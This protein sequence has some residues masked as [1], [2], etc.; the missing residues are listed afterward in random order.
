MDREPELI[1]TPEAGP[2]VIRGSLIRTVGWVGGLALGALSAPLIIRHLGEAEYGRFLPII[3]LVAVIA[4][5]ADNAMANVAIREYSAAHRDERAELLRNL[6]GMRLALTGAGLAIVLGFAVLAGYTKTQIAGMA[7]AGLGLVV[8][9]YQGA[10][11]APMAVGLRLGWIS[12]IEMVRQVVTVA[13]IAAFVIAGAGLLPFFIAAPAGSAAALVVTAALVRRQAPWVPAFDRARWRRVFGQVLP[14][15]A[16]TTFGSLYFRIVLIVMSLAGTAAQ[17]GHFSVSFRIMEIVLAVPG[18]IVTSAFPILARAAQNDRARLDYALS[19]IGEVGVILGTWIALSLWLLA[20]LAID[21]VSGGRNS[22]TIWA[23]RLQ[24]LS[25]P[26]SFL[27]ASWAAG[28]LSLR[29][30]RD[31]LLVNSSALVT[32]LV[33]SLALIG[34]LGAKG[35]ALAISLTELL[36]AAAYG[37][38]VR[39]RSAL[40][41]A[42]RVTL[43]VPVVTAA[44]VAAGFLMPGPEPIG[45]IVAT[46]IYFGVLLAARAVPAEIL[47]ALTRR[48]P[49]AAPADPA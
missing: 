41:L 16:A 36:L 5:I 43:L 37:L 46:A 4:I 33:L 18:V 10:V 42:P 40:R 48:G 24:S 2:V 30:N 13:A 8:A 34:P 38:A 44:A 49:A 31:L 6:L 1:D 28:L 27:I 45:A 12:S 17:T 9:D 7:I 47:E 19:R 14:V 32:S 21:L 39:R 23:L 25:M 15:A 35:G 22:E 11:Q 20:P 26:A 3:S 29:A